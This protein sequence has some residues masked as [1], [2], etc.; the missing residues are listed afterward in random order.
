MHSIRFHLENPDAPASSSHDAWMR[1][2]IEAG[3]KY[4]P[5]TNPETRE[6]SSLVPFEQLSQDDQAKDHLFRAIVLALAPYMAADS[7]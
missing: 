3:W 7:C 4:G 5:V 6:H 2:K 1:E